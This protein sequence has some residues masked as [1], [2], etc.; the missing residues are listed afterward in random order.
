MCRLSSFLVLLAIMPVSLVGHSAPNPETSYRTFKQVGLTPSALP[1]DTGNAFAHARG[2]G[3]FIGNGRLDFFRASVT[4]FGTNDWKPLAEATLAKFEFWAR[5][6]NGTFVLDAGRIASGEGCL[7]PRKALVADFN[8]DGKPDIFVVCHGYDKAPFPGE[9][10]KIVLSRPDGRY[11]I[12]DA[13]ND[14]GFFHGGV[15]VDVNGDG[16]VDVILVNNFDPNS[17]AVLLN[18]GAGTF[19]REST[20]RL[21]QLGQK[22]YFNIEVADVNDD[23]KPDLLLGGHDWEGA[24]TIVLLNPGNFD[25]SNVAPVVLPAVLNEGVVTDFTVT[26]S[27]ASKVIWV[28]RTSGGDGTFYQSLILQKV[29]WPSLRSTV[30]L[31]RRP[32]QWTEWLLPTY[33]NG[34]LALAS[35]NSSFGVMQNVGLPLSRRGSIDLQ[36][37]GV[38]TLMLKNTSSDILAGRLVNNAFSFSSMASPGGNNRL[39]AAA[40]FDA[41]GISDLAYQNMTQG[42]FGDVKI[43]RSFVGA[44]EV[45]WRQVKQVW[46]VQAIGDLDGDGFADLVWRYVADDPRDTGVSYIWFTNASSVTQVRKRGGAPLSWTL[47]GAADLN[48]DGAAD[49][50]YISP[51]RQ[52][53]ALMATANRTCANFAAGT[54]PAGFT[55]LKLADFSGGNRGDILLRNSATGDT[56]LLSLSAAG[57]TMPAP[58]ANPDD[59]NA[60]CT[61]TSQPLLSFSYPMPRTESNWRF[62]AS[63]D[64]NGDGISDVVW[65]RPDNSLAV[66]LMNASGAQPW[67]I[68][69]AG[70]VPAGYVALQP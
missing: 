42:V 6:T 23:G 4:Y 38:G 52:I 68:S 41:D 10:N 56:Q 39:L 65:I 13:S 57:L 53:R 3:D 8:S 50:I 32:A 51:D 43:W 11:N 37:Q 19:V 14:V 20:R 44:N 16:H 70:T 24:P 1:P 18:Q 12:V 61:A 26:G 59:P 36:G 9:R 54:I 63:G 30:V 27:G 28:L 40:D 29:E 58:S 31:S 25:F 60:S 69:N 15:A 66:W 67:L 46:D 47:L 48:G 33:V 45:F 55:A 35:D 64:F 49:M 34:R 21:P 17:S 2:Y 62:F 7:H 5:Q 22:S